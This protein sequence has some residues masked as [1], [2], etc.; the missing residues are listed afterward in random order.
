M[1][2][3]LCRWGAIELFHDG[4]IRDPR[5][6]GREL[7]IL[8]KSVELIIGTRARVGVKFHSGMTL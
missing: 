4:T 1:G 6:R 5:A 2:V 8:P 7:L 3:L